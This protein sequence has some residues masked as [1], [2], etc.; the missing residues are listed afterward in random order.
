MPHRD[1][2]VKTCKQ[3]SIF[4]DCKAHLIYSYTDTLVYVIYLFVL[5]QSWIL[6]YYVFE[7]VTDTV[8]DII[9]LQF[10]VTSHQSV[11]EDIDKEC[12]R[13]YCKLRNEVLC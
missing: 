12:Y 4:T 11:S 2:R 10:G 13:R 5:I 8:C 6:G 7:Y 1:N 3:F 9:H